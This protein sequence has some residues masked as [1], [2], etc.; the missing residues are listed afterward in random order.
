MPHQ[1]TITASEIGDYVF[2]K[3]SWWLRM[4]G[5]LADNEKL[6]EGLRGHLQVAKDLAEKKRKMV[7]GIIIVLTGIII[8]TL[9]FFL[10]LIHI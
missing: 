2:C 5:M 7:L 10:T 3:R 1:M 8:G 9:L 4:Q 6:R